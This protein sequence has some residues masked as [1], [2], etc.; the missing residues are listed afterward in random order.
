[1]SFHYSTKD[2]GEKTKET[3]QFYI[4]LILSEEGE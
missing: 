2:G 1:M 3:N 4:S